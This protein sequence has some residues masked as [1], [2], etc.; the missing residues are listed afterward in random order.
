MEKCG[1]QNYLHCILKWFILHN[2]LIKLIFSKSDLEFIYNFVL[3][4]IFDIKFYEIVEKFI[5][6]ICNKFCMGESNEIVRDFEKETNTFIKPD[7]QLKKE[8]RE[9]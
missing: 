4:F 2:S 9:K 7:K 6:C 1:Y 8:Q 5:K 3:I